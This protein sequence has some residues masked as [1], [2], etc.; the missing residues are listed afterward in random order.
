MSDLLDLHSLKYLLGSH[1]KP[2]DHAMLAFELS[3]NVKSSVLCDN[4]KT[5]VSGTASLKQKMIL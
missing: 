2:P 1:C 5:D 3:V 4:T